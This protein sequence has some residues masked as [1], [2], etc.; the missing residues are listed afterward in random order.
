MSA[1]TSASNRSHTASSSTPGS[2][3]ATQRSAH[4]A[5]CCRDRSPDRSPRSW[6]SMSE[7]DGGGG[8]A[9]FIAP[10]SARAHGPTQDARSGDIPECSPRSASFARLS[11]LD[12]RTCSASLRRLNMLSADSA[13]HATELGPKRRLPVP[14]RRRDEPAG[15]RSSVSNVNPAAGTTQETDQASAGGMFA[16]KRRR[17][18]GSRRRLSC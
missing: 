12:S 16:L 9:S 10:V 2:L 5:T 17:F 4:R 18:A 14:D 3:A 11:L 13:S 8:G 7:R 6:A 1:P 15:K